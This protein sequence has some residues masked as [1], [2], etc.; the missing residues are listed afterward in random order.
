M[1]LT[2]QPVRLNI[3][4]DGE[5]LL[6]PAG[7]ETNVGRA[8]E[9]L[10]LEIGPHGTYVTLVLN[11]DIDSFDFP[12]DRVAIGTRTSALDGLTPFE[13]E[14]AAVAK[15][16]GTMWERIYRHLINRTGESHD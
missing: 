3:N 9:Q 12:V 5:V 10:N 4:A 16:E 11:A 6:G 15:G 7:F 14:R 1:A 2:T 13:L 8:V